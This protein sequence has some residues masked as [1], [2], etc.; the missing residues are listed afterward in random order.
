MV[1]LT[2]KSA[3]GRESSAA[4]VPPRRQKCIGFT[5]RPPQNPTVHSLQSTDNSSPARRRFAAKDRKERKKANGEVE[6]RVC[7]AIV[8]C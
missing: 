6:V 4:Q 5:P 1:M 8:Q 3:K 7:S 2:T